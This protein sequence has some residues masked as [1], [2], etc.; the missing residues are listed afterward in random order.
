MGRRDSGMY[1]GAVE[2]YQCEFRS[3]PVFVCLPAVQLHRF[4]L[5]FL[6][7]FEGHCPPLFYIAP[8]DLN[9]LS[10][11][12]V[13]YV[14]TALASLLIR[15]RQVVAQTLTNPSQR[16]S[17]PITLELLLPP[18][19]AAPPQLAQLTRAQWDGYVP[20]PTRVTAYIPPASTTR[21]ARAGR[22]TLLGTTI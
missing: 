5:P 10:I 8:P 3:W 22:G 4:F 17:V 21:L 11:L 19:L 9:P 12:A 7:G 16:P 20:L 13:I 1:I 18:P 15:L 6:S 14:T 2:R